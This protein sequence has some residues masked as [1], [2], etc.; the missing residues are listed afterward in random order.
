MADNSLNKGKS[1]TRRRVQAAM[2]EH[3]QACHP[4]PQHVAARAAVDSVSDDAAGNVGKGTAFAE[5]RN[6]VVGTGRDSRASAT[7]GNPSSPA[8]GNPVIAQD[9]NALRLSEPLTAGRAA[10][11]TGDHGVG[12]GRN[13]ALA[14]GVPGR[15]VEQGGTGRIPF[16]S[17][18]AINPNSVNYTGAVAFGGIGQDPSSVHLDVMPAAERAGLPH[19]LRAPV[20]GRPNNAGTT[21]HMAPQ[22]MTPANPSIPSG[23]MASASRPPM[24]AKAESSIGIDI[25]KATMRRVDNG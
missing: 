18:N 12:Q 8:I 19:G 10:Y 5:D 2:A 22:S 6:S 20:S 1:R 4:T 16:A 9:F 23:Q 15:H 24:S 7:P 21:P 3:V 11:S 14:V 17:M 13:A 25:M